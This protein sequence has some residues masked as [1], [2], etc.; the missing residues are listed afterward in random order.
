MSNVATLAQAQ[1]SGLQITTMDEAMRVADVLSKS[2]LVPK[3][4]MGQPGNVMLAIMWGKELGLAPL[5]AMQ[6]IAVINGRPS[7][8]GD[9][10]MAMVRGSGQLESISETDD[11][12]TA[13]C[14]I[15]RK[16]ETEQSRTFSMEDAQLAGLS[17]KQGPWRMYPKRMRQL[18]AR[19]FALRDI[20]ADILAGMHIADESIDLPPVIKDITPAPAGKKSGVSA[21]KAKLKA[22]AEPVEADVVADTPEVS[23][24]M[25][26]AMEAI[27]AAATKAELASAGALAGLIQDETEKGLARS[28]YTLKIA[29][30]EG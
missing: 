8:W 6:S 12:D 7:I 22:K 2:T 4:Y 30:L 18:R 9:A 13:T 26:Q 21:V 1:P 24:A 23:I 29:E 11:G 15:K 25:H 27:E 20:F 28:A 17:G 19:S 16:G 10:L 3:D 14:T 5:Q